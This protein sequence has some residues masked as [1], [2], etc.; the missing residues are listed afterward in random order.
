LVLLVETEL[1][2]CTGWRDIHRSGGA[3]GSLSKVVRLSLPSVKPHS[4]P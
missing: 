4:R 3:L 1:V 2:F